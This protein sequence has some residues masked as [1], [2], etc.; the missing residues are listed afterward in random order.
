[1]EKVYLKKSIVDG[2]GVVTDDYVQVD[3]EDLIKERWP[4]PTK[5][6]AVLDANGHEVVNPIPVAPP[7]GYKRE[8]SLAEQVRQAVR[9]E[10]QALLDLEPETMEEADDFEVDDEAVP[11]SPWE[12]DLVP[13]IKELRRRALEAGYV[14][15]QQTHQYELPPEASEMIQEPELPLAPT[16]AAKKLKPASKAAPK[17]PE[18]LSDNED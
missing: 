17:P 10:R 9:L 2:D 13:T 12:N 6:K 4:D 3:L 8:L 11:N 5:G 15:N 14:Y 1:M 18:P 7:V 16:P